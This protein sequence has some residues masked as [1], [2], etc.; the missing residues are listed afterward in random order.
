MSSRSSISALI[1][2]IEDWSRALDQGQEVCVV[3]FDIKKAFDTVPLIQVIEDWSRALDQDLQGS[4]ASCHHAH[5][6]QP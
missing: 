6:S 2:V 1:Q 3:F 5:L 4:G